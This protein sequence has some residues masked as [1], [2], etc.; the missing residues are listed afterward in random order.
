MLPVDAT[1]R[2]RQIVWI[3]EPVGPASKSAN[4]AHQSGPPVDGAVRPVSQ[5]KLPQGLAEKLVTWAEKVNA[6]HPLY[7]LLLVTTG[8]IKLM[9]CKQRQENKPTSYI[10]SGRVRAEPRHNQGRALPSE[11]CLSQ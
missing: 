3:V 5:I 4:Q 2:G 8:M 9:V 11:Y 10:V 6:G 1:C 7:A